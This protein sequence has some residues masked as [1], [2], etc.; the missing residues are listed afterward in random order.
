MIRI[1]IKAMTENIYIWTMD[2]FEIDA[3]DILL[4]F[5][6]DYDIRLWY[7]LA[8]LWKKQLH[9]THEDCTMRV[10]LYASMLF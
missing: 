6:T 5:V 8:C 2:V 10:K 7:P 1:L 4:L 3:L 9:G